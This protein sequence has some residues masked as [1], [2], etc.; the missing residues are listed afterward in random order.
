[1]GG[2]YTYRLTAMPGQRHPTKLSTILIV[3]YA[4]QI[5]CSFRAQSCTCGLHSIISVYA[6]KTG[7]TVEKSRNKP[8]SQSHA[9]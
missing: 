5:P 3:D 9:R 4:S 1:M 8:N 2:A 7:Y 6:L